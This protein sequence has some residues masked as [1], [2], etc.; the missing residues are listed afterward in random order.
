M[1]GVCSDAGAG[2]DAGVAADGKIRTI[3]PVAVESSG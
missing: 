2:D 3:V 1:C